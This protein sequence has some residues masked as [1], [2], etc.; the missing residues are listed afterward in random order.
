MQLGALADT[1]I[2]SGIR[3][4]EPSLL[5]VDG[6]VGRKVKNVY[7]QALTTVKFAVAG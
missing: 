7:A 2:S 4:P 5:Y 6:G 3:L 1:S